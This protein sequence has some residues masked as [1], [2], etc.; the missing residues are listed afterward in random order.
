MELVS[1]VGLSTAQGNELSWST[2]NEINND[3]FEIEKSI[4]G[5][6]YTTVGGVNG[7]GNSTTL[8]SYYFTDACNTSEKTYYR[9]H[10]FDVDGKSTYSKTVVVISVQELTLQASPNPFKDQCNITVTGLKSESTAQLT[11]YDLI[12]NVYTN[13]MIQVRNGAYEIGKNLPTDIY[14]IALKSQDKTTHLRIMKTK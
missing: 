14:I 7:S 12:G 1:F 8:L 4:D 10:Q 5:N 9:L 6:T 11:I 3:R 13:E 2:A